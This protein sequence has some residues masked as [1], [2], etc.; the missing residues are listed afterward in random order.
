MAGSATM[1]ATEPSSDPTTTPPSMMPTTHPMIVP[2]ASRVTRA[3]GPA[4]QRG[5]RRGPLRAGMT[6]APRSRRS[7]TV[8]AT[9]MP[10]TRAS[11]PSSSSQVRFAP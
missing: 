11:T 6:P 4:S 8:T 10:T 1:S 9:A 2:R 3:K 7:S 5:A